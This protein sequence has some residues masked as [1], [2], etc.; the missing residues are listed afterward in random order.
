MS[1]ITQTLRP[2]L[3]TEPGVVGRSTQG[4]ITSGS[5][6]PRSVLPETFLVCNSLGDRYDIVSEEQKSE[7]IGQNHHEAWEVIPPSG[8]DD[9]TFPLIL[10]IIEGE[11]G[12]RKPHRRP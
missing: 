1:S 10:C 5:T 11:G 7:A 8:G 2:R 12:G 9:Y 4:E 6:R 3:P